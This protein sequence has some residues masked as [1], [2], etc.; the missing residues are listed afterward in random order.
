MK[1]RWRA[2]IDWIERHA[3]AVQAV[4]TVVTMLVAIAALVGVKAQIDASAR[5]QREQSARDIYRE[6]L[7][8]SV[9]RPEFARPDYC[10]IVGG[11]TEPAYEAYVDYLLYTAEQA[12]A[13]DPAWR[14]GFARQLQV[15]APYLCTVD[16][17]SDYTGAVAELIGE[18]RRR[19]GAAPAC[20]E[21]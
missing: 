21:Q 3:V 11:S 13:A 7:N 18:T 8:L 12:I 6:Y 5:L 16:D 2:W 1:L 4:A 9:S 10:A 17:W 19:C 20:A 14:E 15:H